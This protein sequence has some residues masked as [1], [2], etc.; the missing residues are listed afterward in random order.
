MFVAARRSMSALA[1]AATCFGLSACSPV[2]PSTSQTQ[3]AWDGANAPT[4][5][6]VQS[7]PYLNV[8][9]SAYLPDAKLGWSGDYWP[10]IK[11]GISDRWQTNRSDSEDYTNHVYAPLT[12]QA[13][14]RLTNA[15]LDKLSPAEKYDIL[16]GRL[17]FPLTRAEKGAVL[18][19]R[20]A[21]GD[22]PSWHGIC[23]GWSAASIRE[24]Q[25]GK[26]AR[27]DLG[28]GRSLTFNYGDLQAL[29]SRAYAD[30]D[31]YDFAF[32]GGRC[33][34]QTVRFDAQ[35]RAVD[36]ECRDVNPGA[37][38]LILGDYLGRRQESFI[39]DVH[40]GEQVWNQPIVG[41]KLTYSNERGLQG[42]RL[43]GY[44]APGTQ[45]LVDVSAQLFYLLE[46]NT[47]LEP[48][49]PYYDSVTVTYS[50]ELDSRGY[51]LGG[52]WTSKDRPDFLWSVRSAPRTNSSSLIDYNTVKRLLD[53]SHGNQPLPDP[54]PDP[55]PIPDPDP[56]PGPVT[57][58]VSD[59]RLVNDIGLRPVAVAT[60]Y[61]YGQGADAVEMVA[62]LGN[63]DLRV[64]D[65]QPV[66]ADGRFELRGRVALRAAGIVIRVIDRNG[67][68]LRVETV[69]W[70]T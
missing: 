59:F 55:D 49:R 13:A 44:R 5:F 40:N 42:D 24:K 27:V 31:T 68:V 26:A 16:T 33:D 29:A 52:E 22:V 47:S 48:T 19:A 7:A 63:G 8:A 45:R 35:G 57:L 17:D 56:T 38:H 32:L 60:G 54:T 15:Q 64:L 37:F 41:Y 12:A 62:D 65:G 53:L 58:T 36:S 34:A 21:S 14:S 67:R 2:E 51:V 66:S 25:P 61:A 28:A 69:A 46:S 20:D 39:A 6:G 3:E 4:I 11:G 70:G 18:A 10:T 23:H 50:L 30:F 43:A 1:F 9:A